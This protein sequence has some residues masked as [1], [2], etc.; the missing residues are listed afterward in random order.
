[1]QGGMITGNNCV[2]RIRCGPVDQAFAGKVFPVGVVHELISHTQPDAVATNAFVTALLG[3]L[4]Q[5]DGMCLWVGTRRTVFPP[6]LQLF[7]VN[8]D[9]VIFITPNRPRDVLWVIEE[10]LKCSAVVAVVGEIRSL[11]FTESRRLQLAVEESGV[12][13]FIHRN[14]PGNVNTV[15]CHTRWHITTLASMPGDMPGVGYPRWNVQLEKV[16][17]G[18]PGMW[19]A[20]WVNGRF[21][22]IPRPQVIQD[23]HQLKAG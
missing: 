16:R 23:V 22:F 13:G 14:Q 19:Q 7:N 12:T 8:P 9:R 3:Q 2:R 11:G 10:S 1:M 15:A 4:M 18:K 17:N 21:N 6:A 5:G 20:E